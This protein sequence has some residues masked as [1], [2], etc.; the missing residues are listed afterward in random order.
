MKRILI[1]VQYFLLEIIENAPISS[2]EAADKPFERFFELNSMI[3]KL[4]YQIF[5]MV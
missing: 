1:L 5:M 3:K 4:R 2:L